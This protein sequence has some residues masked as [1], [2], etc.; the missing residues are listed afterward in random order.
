MEVMKKKLCI[1]MSAMLLMLAGTVM[2]ACSSDD[3]IDTPGT[4]ATGHPTRQLPQLADFIKTV[5][6]MGYLMCDK[7]DNTWFIKSPYHGQEIRYDGGNIYYLYDLP[8]EYQKEGL[9]VKASL[10]CYT[11]LHFNERVEHMWYAGYD[12]YDAVL[13]DIEIV[14]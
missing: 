1:I 5:T 4:S 9:K 3:D 13:R 6:D 2:T 8:V 10:D 11:F 14:E 12:Y 7:V